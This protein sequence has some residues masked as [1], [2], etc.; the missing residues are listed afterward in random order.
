MGA[1]ARCERALR[2]NADAV[3]TSTARAQ[4]PRGSFHATAGPEIERGGEAAA[5]APGRDRDRGR[6]LLP[7]S[8][9]AL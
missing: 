8:G 9:A 6:L 1:A 2:V 7:V 4:T 3:R 5:S